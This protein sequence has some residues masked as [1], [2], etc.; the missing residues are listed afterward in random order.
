MGVFGFESSWFLVLGWPLRGYRSSAIIHP[1]SFIRHR[2][3]AAIA[4]VG[5]VNNGL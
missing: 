5:E 1:P 2:R 4:A 3:Y